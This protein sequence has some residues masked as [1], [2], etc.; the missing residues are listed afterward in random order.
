M[1]YMAGMIQADELMGPAG[2]TEQE[3]ERHYARDLEMLSA[4]KGGWRPSQGVM[5]ARLPVRCSD[6]STGCDPPPQQLQA[7][8]AR[9]RSKAAGLRVCVF[10]CTRAQLSWPQ[11][12]V[13]PRHSTCTSL[14]STSRVSALAS[15]YTP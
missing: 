15:L 2:F 10:P 12:A 4:R 6:G 9:R 8:R 13:A 5:P 3:M 14:C 7:T 1:I 11:S